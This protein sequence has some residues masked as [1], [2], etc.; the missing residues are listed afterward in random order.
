MDTAK[1]VEKLEG[2]LD[3]GHKKRRKRHDKLLKIIKKLEARKSAI[4]AEIVEQGKT[5]ETS[6]RYRELRQ[7]MKVVTRLIKKARKQDITD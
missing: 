5:D 2:Y 1:L 6:A 3:L 7:E 4:E